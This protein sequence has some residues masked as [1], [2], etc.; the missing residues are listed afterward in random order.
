MKLDLAKH[1][2]R[3][4]L[5]CVTFILLPFSWMFGLCAALRRA[6]YKYH[7]LKS[8][9]FA[10]P[11]IVVGNITVGGTGKTPFV[12]WLVHLLQAQGYRPGIVSRGVG[13]KT[14]CQPHIVCADDKAERVG[15]EALLLVRNVDAPLVICKNRAAA[16]E[17]LLRHTNCNIVVSDDGLQH[18]RLARDIEIAMVDGKRQFGNQQLLP[19]GPLREPIERLQG[20]DFQVVN[21]GE[22]DN[23]MT[24]LP[25]SLVNVCTAKKLN[26]PVN[27]IST[28]HAVAGIGHP[29]RFF[30]EL[31]RLGFTLIPHAF[32][33]HYLYAAHDLDFKDSLPILMTEKDAVKCLSFADDRYWYLKITA[34]I[35]DE[36]KEKLLLKIKSKITTLGEQ[37]DDDENTISGCGNDFNCTVRSKQHGEKP[38][39]Y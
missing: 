27:N 37:Q 35:S 13:G 31:Q 24:L 2:Y 9:R 26:F 23:A 12:I 7:I 20:V 32:A 6:L 33:D 8:Y 1:W 15:D 10:V 38:S 4:S 19:A 14:H 21:G 17:H 18:Y 16:V 28:V 11:V 25:L 39:S 5:T 3:S 22:G 34:K 29:E 36:L 30:A